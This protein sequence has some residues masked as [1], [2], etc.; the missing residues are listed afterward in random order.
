MHRATEPS[1]WSG[2]SSGSPGGLLAIGNSADFP[3]VTSV[4][5]KPLTCDAIARRNHVMKYT[6]RN[7]LASL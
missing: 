6:G 2:W 1:G 7:L 4:Y 5:L 3:P